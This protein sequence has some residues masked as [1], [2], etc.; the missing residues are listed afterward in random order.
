VPERHFA[1]AVEDLS[2][3]SSMLV[4][5]TE[6]PVALHR[7]ESGEFFATAD[8]CTHEEFSLSE[9]GEIEGTELVCPLHMA[10]FDLP[11]GA[12]LC[13]PATIAL[14]TYGVE[15]EDGNAYVVVHAPLQVVE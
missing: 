3:G 5:G 10:R 9:D 12:P 14:A 6:P 4:E 2:P 7:A 1:C 11:T 13:L 15:V 8:S